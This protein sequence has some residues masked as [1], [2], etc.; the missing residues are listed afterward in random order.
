MRPKQQQRA[1]A[2]RMMCINEI[3][4]RYAATANFSKQLPV[5]HLRK[6]PSAIF[7]RR[8]HAEHADTSKAI[9]HATRNV[10]LPIDLRSIEMFIEELAQFAE[11]FVEL[12]LLRSG[13]ARIRH[14]PIGN[15]MALEKSF[16]KAQRLRPRK[17][18]FLSLLNFFLSLRVEFVHLVRIQSRRAQCN[19][20]RPRV[21]S[22]AGKSDYPA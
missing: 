11:R 10:C 6:P 21:Q 16:R 3:R 1:N 2:E 4:C 14:H 5:G 19:H 7:L 17:K 22:S 18:Q 15:E 20:V 13:D 9:N 8:G 12:D